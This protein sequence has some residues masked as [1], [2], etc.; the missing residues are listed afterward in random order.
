MDEDDL[1]SNK[2]KD[3]HD[4]FNM[5]Q[6]IDSP[7]HILGH[8]LDI[9]ATFGN[10]PVISNIVSNEYGVSHLVDF[11]VGIVPE[12]KQVKDITYRN[13]KDSQRMCKKN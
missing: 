12:T 7:T 3:I 13:L 5:T 10:K 6:H 4:T 9:V 1:Y 11:H 2:F 8:T